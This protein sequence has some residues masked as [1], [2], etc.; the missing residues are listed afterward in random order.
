MEETLSAIIETFTP[1][2]DVIETAT[3]A[4]SEIATEAPSGSTAGIVNTLENFKNSV[5]HW[6]L[7]SGVRLVIAV[8]ILFVAF[9]LINFIAKRI[10]KRL[11]KRPKVDKTLS[12]TLI[13]VSKIILKILVVVMLISF[14][15]IDTSV[16]SALF[17]S[18]GVTIGL[19]VNGALGNAAGGMLL[20]ITRPFSIDD[21]VDIAGSC[22]TVEDIKIC[23]TKL[24]T[25]DNKVIYVPNGIASSSTIVNYS[26]KD[27]R[28]VDL[29][30]TISYGDDSARAVEIIL[31]TANADERILKEPALPFAAVASY[32]SSSVLIKSRNWVKSADYW[33]VYFDMLTKVRQN[34]E[35]AGMTIPFNQLD[36]HIK[37]E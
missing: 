32:D 28:R 23:N 21:Y 35:A 8:I 30:F 5:V 6:L 25:V 16:F 13:Y 2:P 22:G 33:A 19:A 1:S 7:T 18:I 9:W 34:L 26:E 24:R 27:L 17:A 20:L 10:K 15:G 14:V 11:D 3:N 12:K 31:E 37:A 4:A 36:V 29:E